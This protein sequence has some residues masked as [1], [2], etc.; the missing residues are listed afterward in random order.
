MK[1]KYTRRRTSNAKAV[2]LILTVLIALGIAVFESCQTKQPATDMPQKAGANN[3]VQT[4]KT[5]QNVEIVSVYDGDTFKINPPCEVDLFC[6]TVSVRVRGV[7]TPE[8]KGKTE[9]EKQLAQKAK[10]FTQEFLKKGPITLTN[11]GRDKYF[12]LLC[13]VQN[14]TGKDLA[15]ALIEANLG[16]AYQGG[17]K[18]KMYQ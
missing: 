9:R 13:N 11:C 17:T 8:I 14:N 10:K 15:Q 1:K 6:D 5:I 16:Y 2:R 4:E 7:D 3:Q 12:R 18:S